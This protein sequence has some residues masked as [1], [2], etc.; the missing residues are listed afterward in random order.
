M[1]P[2]LRPA[3]LLVDDDET[4]LS[5]LAR[6]LAREGFEVRTALSGRSALAALERGWPALLVIDLMMPGMDGFELSRRVKQIADLPIIILSAVDASESKVRA[7][8]T[9]AEDYVTKPFDPDEL[10]AR[11][12][13][14]LRRSSVGAPG[15]TLDG[16]DLEIDLS[17]RRLV[18]PAGTQPLTPTEV[19]LLQVLVGA[20]DRT[21][22]TETLL[23]RVW[24]DADGADP[25]YVWV[26][27]RRLRR[28][29]EVDPDNP[30][31]LLTERGV[32]YRLVSDSVG[33]AAPAR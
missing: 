11:V 26:T 10:V 33:A 31:Y 3:L 4:L 28:K 16:G 13:R 17:G 6:R 23:E 2:A 25:S 15:I 21:V 7:L 8:E 24:S 29:L 18:T 30:R 19:R 22:R 14:V 1:L 12:Q 9:Y 27:V 5:V 32:G 20:L